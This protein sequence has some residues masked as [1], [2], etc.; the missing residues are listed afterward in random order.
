MEELNCENSWKAVVTC[1]GWMGWDGMRQEGA[2][3]ETVALDKGQARMVLFIVPMTPIHRG[4]FLSVFS[5]FR[6]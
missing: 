1:G 2:W 6:L 5:H 3:L 4:L